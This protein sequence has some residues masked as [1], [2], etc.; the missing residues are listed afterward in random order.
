MAIRPNWGKG[1][2]LRLIIFEETDHL[3]MITTVNDWFASL[4]EEEIL[5][6]W[7]MNDVYGTP[8]VEHYHVSILYTLE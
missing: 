1:R 3:T 6:L 8:A 7:Q 4:G 5:D 2:N